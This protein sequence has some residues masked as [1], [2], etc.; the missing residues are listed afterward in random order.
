LLL[1]EFTNHPDK[2]GLKSDLILTRKQ[3]EID[4]V[5]HSIENSK[6]CISRKEIEIKLKRSNLEEQMIAVEK[7]EKAMEKMN[8]E[9]KLV[10]CSL[11]FQKQAEEQ[12]TKRREIMLKIRN[13]AVYIVIL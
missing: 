1:K 4:D 6:K 13:A 3:L 7:Y 8:A 9:I 12:T 11:N 10:Q 2:H 5:M